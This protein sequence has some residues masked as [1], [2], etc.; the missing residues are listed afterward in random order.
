M[1]PSSREQQADE[2]HWTKY[3]S[4]ELYLETS[5]PDE[6]ARYHV[7]LTPPS[8]PSKSPLFVCHHGAGACGLSFAI[9]AREIRQKFPEAGVLSLEARGHGSTLTHPT[10]NE[11]L[12][13]YSLPALTSDA[14][15]MITL[16]TQTLSW[17]H[18]PPTILIG[19]SLGGAIVTNLAMHHQQTLAPNF[20]GYAVLDVVEGSALEALTHMEN[21]LASR[22]SIFASQQAAITWQLRSRTLRSPESAAVSVPPLL[23]PTPNP[24]TQKLEYTWKT[25]LALT[26]THWSSWFTGMSAR[27]LQG[28]GAKLLILAGTDRLDKELMVGQMQGKFQLVV[29]PEAGHFV[30]EDAAAK[31]A[32]VVGEF[33][34]RNDRGGLVLPM[35]VDEMIRLGKKV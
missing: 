15:K 34:R 17:P 27:F 1:R 8:D 13:D 35:K 20:I 28:R 24:E 33:Y 5:S 9:F 6:K 16:T 22:P 26:T 19:H 4:Q 10:T 25:P 12:T 11:E 23:T 21:Y 7:Y 2:H 31:V 18:L 3:F 14:L 29:V 30:Q 32:E